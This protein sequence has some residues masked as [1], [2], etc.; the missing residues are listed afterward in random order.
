MLLYP[1]PLKASWPQDTAE[2]SGLGLSLRMLLTARIVGIQEL[3]KPAGSVS[4]WV[5]C[6]L[7][8]VLS[9]ESH[10]YEHLWA[11]V[12]VPAMGPIHLIGLWLW[13]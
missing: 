11:T 4:F 10:H 9:L 13:K 12:Y 7:S 3:P 2:G 1:L 6:H 8:A 5:F